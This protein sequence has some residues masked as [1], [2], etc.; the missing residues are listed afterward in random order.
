MSCTIWGARSCCLHPPTLTGRWLPEACRHATPTAS[1]ACKDKAFAPC[2]R[3]LAV[4]ILG[5]GVEWC[6]MAEMG[7]T[8]GALATRGVY[9]VSHGTDA[10]NRKHLKERISNY[11]WSISSKKRWKRMPR[12]TL[13][14]RKM[15]QGRKKFGRSIPRD[16]I[17][18]RLKKV[19]MQF[20]EERELCLVAWTRNGESL[21]WGWR[22]MKCMQGSTEN[23]RLGWARWTKAGAISGKPECE[24]PW[25]SHKLQVTLYHRNHPRSNP[26]SQEKPPFFL[27]H[28]QCGW[29]FRWKRITQDNTIH[30]RSFCMK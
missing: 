11:L 12:N 10:W 18:T 24:C 22:A 6:V 29:V 17:Q 16:R 14:W 9:Q 2:I 19:E 30:L 5:Q 23:P 27:Q 1:P 8:T 20:T 4:G 15:R 13:W 7:R 25:A 26:R 28:L 3:V 21:D